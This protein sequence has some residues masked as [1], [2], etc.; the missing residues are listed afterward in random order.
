MT[1]AREPPRVRRVHIATGIIAAQL[2]CSVD[3]ALARLLIRTRA[4]GQTPDKLAMDVIDRV[5]R[6]EP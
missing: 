6:F 5:I 3:E 1:S 4:T 2:D